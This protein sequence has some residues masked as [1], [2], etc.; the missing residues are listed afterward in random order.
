MLSL[1]YYKPE[2]QANWKNKGPS[3]NQCKNNIISD[4]KNRLLLFKYGN[5]TDTGER[6]QDL[7]IQYVSSPENQ[8]FP[9]DRQEKFKN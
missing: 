6:I 5:E 1:P 4:M 8:E 2:T 9:D 7:L 3:G